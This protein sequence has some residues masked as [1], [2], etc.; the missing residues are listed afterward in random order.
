MNIKIGPRKRIIEI[1]SEFKNCDGINN[2]EIVNNIEPET[3]NNTQ[4]FD[5]NV[6]LLIIDNDSEENTE[7]SIPINENTTTE[8]ISANS[9]TQKQSEADENLPSTSTGTGRNFKNKNI[10]EPRYLCVSINL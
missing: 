6:P 2:A 1:I 5:V 4:T 7:I 10:H 8:T 3:T 9:T